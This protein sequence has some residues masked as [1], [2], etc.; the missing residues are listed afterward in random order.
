MKTIGHSV[1]RKISEHHHREQQSNVRHRRTDRSEQTIE[2]FCD[3]Y[4]IA[5]AT[6]GGLGGARF[7]TCKTTSA[8]YDRASRPEPQH[9]VRAG[10]ER[11]Q[12][13]GISGT[14]AR[15]TDCR[16]SGLRPRFRPSVLMGAR[17]VVVSRFTRAGRF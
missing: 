11:N 9:R 15:V 2:R 10:P 5:P 14:R 17:R 12:S 7:T 3:D 6:G 16:R 8:I 1:G 13:Y 4:S